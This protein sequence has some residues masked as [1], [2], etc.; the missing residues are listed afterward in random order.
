LTPA[1]ILLLFEGALT[2]FEKLSPIVKDLFAKGDVS[3]AD[4]QRVI[5]RLNAL[6][7]GGG[8]SGPEW[9]PSKK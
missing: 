9:Q 1:T 8:F 5:D 7:S 3:P 2:A 6:R 4:Q